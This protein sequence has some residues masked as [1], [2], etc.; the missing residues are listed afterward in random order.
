MVVLATQ[1]PPTRVLNGPHPKRTCVIMPSGCGS[2]AGVIACAD[3][4]TT[5][6]KPATAINL[7]IR[8]LHRL[9]YYRP[10]IQ[11]KSA[12]KSQLELGGHDASSTPHEELVADLAYRYGGLGRVDILEKQPTMP[13]Y[14]W[15]PLVLLW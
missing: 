7:I 10:I 8:L 11:A 2:G 1:T 13:D 4:A 12:Y 14:Q 15:R 6:T 9:L 3:V 5:K